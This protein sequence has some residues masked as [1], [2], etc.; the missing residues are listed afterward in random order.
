MLCKI[1]CYE[2]YNKTGGAIAVGVAQSKDNNVVH[3]R[4]RCK[5]KQRNHL[6]TMQRFAVTFCSYCDKDLFVT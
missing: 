5:D 2:A 3:R 6:L 1:I 4:A